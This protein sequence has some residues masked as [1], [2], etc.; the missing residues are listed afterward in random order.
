MDKKCISFLD[1]ISVWSQ[2]THTLVGYISITTLIPSH[3]LFEATKKVENR[4][5]FTRERPTPNFQMPFFPFFFSKFK[6]KTEFS[7]VQYHE[8]ILDILSLIWPRSL[9]KYRRNQCICHFGFGWR[10]CGNA[11]YVIVWILS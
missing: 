11:Q 8:H 10:L 9:T 5:H 2:H 6:I 3:I 1:L 7:I 4:G